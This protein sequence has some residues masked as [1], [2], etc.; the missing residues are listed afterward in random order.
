MLPI[1]LMMNRDSDRSFVEKLYHQYR[2]NIYASAFKI[3]RHKEDTEDCVQDVIQTVIRH[4]DTF[5]NASRDELIKLLAVCT[6]NAAI[7]IYRKNKRK[8]DR[9]SHLPLD[10]E[11]EAQL[12]PIDRLLYHQ[13]DPAEIVVGKENKRELVQMIAEMDDVY[14]DVLLL[15]YQY[16][17]SNRKIADILKISENTVGVR[18]Y[19]AK[20]MLLEERGEELDEIRK[21][22]SV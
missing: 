14:K 5:R 13:Q 10:R 6:R 1:V 16:R 12:L 17:M 2:K 8:Q 9:E 4:V 22:G 20:K 7:N 21:N 19:R 11:Y 18:L 15:R 3:L